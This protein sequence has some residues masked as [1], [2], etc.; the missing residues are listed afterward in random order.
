MNWE[1]LVLVIIGVIYLSYSILYRNKVTIYNRKENMIVIKKESFLRLQL[2][3]SIIN[4]AYLIILGLIV[5][6]CNIDTMYVLLLI[7][8]FHSINSLLKV[9]SKRKGFIK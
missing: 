3:F 9:I 2:Y 8:I 5:T 7:L 1:G 6:F 4:S